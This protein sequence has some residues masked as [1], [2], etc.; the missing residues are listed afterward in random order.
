MYDLFFEAQKNGKHIFAF[1]SALVG[2]ML[3]PRG[4]SSVSK[5]YIID[6][7]IDLAGS[8]ELYR[9]FLTQP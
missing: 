4:V 8:L 5:I 2:D 3:V 9:S 7:K 6:L 1:K